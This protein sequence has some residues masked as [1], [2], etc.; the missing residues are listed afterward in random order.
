[1]DRDEMKT[2]REIGEERKELP[3]RK[4]CDMRWN[5]ITLNFL[6]LD[7]ILFAIFRGTVS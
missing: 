2:R 6:N 3:G 4:K 7:S 5:E 1:V